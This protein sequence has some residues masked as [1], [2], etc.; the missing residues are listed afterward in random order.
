MDR[1]IKLETDKLAQ[2]LKYLAAMDGL[3]VKKVKE[4]VNEKYG[5]HDSNNNLSNKL[6]KQTFRV[7]ELAEI[8]NILNYEIILRKKS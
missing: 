8:L 1:E 4:L 3:T 7:T 6:R 5:K 2:Q